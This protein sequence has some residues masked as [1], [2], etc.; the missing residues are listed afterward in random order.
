MI[1]HFRESFA[2]ELGRSAAR[3]LVLTALILTGIAFSIFPI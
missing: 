2:K 1:N 3:A